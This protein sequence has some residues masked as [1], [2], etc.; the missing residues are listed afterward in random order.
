MS[1]SMGP[2]VVKQ[3]LFASTLYGRVARCG[4]GWKAVHQ[5]VPAALASGRRHS[6]TAHGV[7]L[8]PSFDDQDGSAA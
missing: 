1:D 3:V 4:C 2:N 5:T 6:W 8:P 7:V